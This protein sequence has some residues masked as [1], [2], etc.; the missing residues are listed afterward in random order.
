MILVCPNLQ[1]PHLIALLNFQTNFLQNF[2]HLIIEYDSPILGWK[3]QMI[4]QYCYIMTL[5]YE[6]AHNPKRFNGSL[7]T[8]L[9]RLKQ[10]SPPSKTT[11]DYSHLVAVLCNFIFLKSFMKNSSLPRKRE[12]SFWALY[13]FL[14]SQE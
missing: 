7:D 11:V 3:H 4:Y 1:K 2:I 9:D 12:S 6:F 10:Y 8:L 14:L 13:G 5:M